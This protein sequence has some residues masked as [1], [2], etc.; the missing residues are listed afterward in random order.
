MPFRPF[1]LNSYV[2][3]CAD[4]PVQ[5]ELEYSR[6]KPGTVDGRTETPVEWDAQRHQYHGRNQKLMA[7]MRAKAS[8]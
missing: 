5:A 6:G 2:R 3:A 8:E 7:D 1:C 4:D